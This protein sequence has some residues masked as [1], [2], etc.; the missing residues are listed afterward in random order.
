M[1]KILAVVLV[2]IMAFAFTTT[3]LADTV[4]VPLGAFSWVNND[5]QKGWVSDGYDG[6]PTSTVWAVVAAST[7]IQIRVDRAPE[8]GSIFIIAQASFN[9]SQWN[10]QEFATADVFTADA[11]GDGGVI[12]I[13]WSAL[14]FWSD[15]AGSDGGKIG[16]G[17]WGDG[18]GD[19]SN[20]GFVSAILVGVPRSVAEEHDVPTTGVLTFVGLAI[21]AF[22]VS[23]GGAVV[24][25]RKLKK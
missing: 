10:Q 3:A 7:G 23:G 19:I 20:L 6:D 8:G 18:T 14:P 17:Y 22:A 16:I 13:S 21:A 5:N 4:G 1:K 15:L 11:E 12:R 25:S 24:I 9:P 2:L